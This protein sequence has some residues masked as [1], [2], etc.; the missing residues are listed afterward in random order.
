MDAPGPVKRIQLEAT[1]IRA[2]GRI[3]ALGVISDSKWGRWDPRR[4]LANRRIRRANG[5]I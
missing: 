2:D 4:W 5:R 3:E 1:V